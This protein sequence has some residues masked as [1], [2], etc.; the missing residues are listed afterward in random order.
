MRMQYWFNI[1]FTDVSDYDKNG[2]TYPFITLPGD[3]ALMSVA[4]LEWLIAFV[5]F[6]FKSY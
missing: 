5:G 1:N 4:R 3:Y 6:A 2:I